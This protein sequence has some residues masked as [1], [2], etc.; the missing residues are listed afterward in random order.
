MGT[1]LV[2]RREEVFEFGMNSTNGRDS[3][4]DTMC[5]SV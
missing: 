1:F 5:I 4:Q 2:I 3:I